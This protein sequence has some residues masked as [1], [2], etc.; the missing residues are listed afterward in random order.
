MCQ[1]TPRNVVPVPAMTPFTDTARSTGA[2]APC[3]SPIT[4]AGTYEPVGSTAENRSNIAID[5]SK[6]ESPAA[7]P[8]DSWPKRSALGP[9]WNGL[10]G[11]GNR[12]SIQVGRDDVV[13][14]GSPGGATTP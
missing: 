6:A 9:H 1:S 11:T 4:F 8:A 5:A 7:I 14:S 2:S 12:S 13:G 3:N 10:D